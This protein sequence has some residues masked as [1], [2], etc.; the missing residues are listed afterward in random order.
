MKLLA[1]FGCVAGLLCAQTEGNYTIR[2]EPR[3]VLQAKT[4]I[5]FEIHVTD[6]RGKPLAGAVVRLQ[7]ETDK[8]TEISMFK[9][10]RCTST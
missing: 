1:L 8:G 10:A 7:V 5:P 6:N 4:D 9:P 3:V 2:F